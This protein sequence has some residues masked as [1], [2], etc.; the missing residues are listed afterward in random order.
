MLQFPKRAERW[1]LEGSAGHD[2]SERND[3]WEADWDQVV[4]NLPRQLA[5][6]VDWVWYAWQE[7]RTVSRN[8]YQRLFSHHHFATDK[9]QSSRSILVDNCTDIPVRGQ[10]GEEGWGRLWRGG[11]RASSL[12]LL[13]LGSTR[14]SAFLGGAPMLRPTI[15]VQGADVQ[16]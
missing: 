4:D 14:A 10:C 16:R 9:N 1:F 11:M 12:R 15:S 8:L 5:N 6:L 3:C 2:Q 13:Q 7:E